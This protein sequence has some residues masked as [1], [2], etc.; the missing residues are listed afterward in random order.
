QNAPLPPLPADV[1]GP[2]NELFGIWNFEPG[3]PRTRT[4]SAGKA[5]YDPS[6]NHKRD[7]AYALMTAD[8]LANGKIEIEDAITGHPAQGHGAQQ[9]ARAV[10]ARVFADADV[11][12]AKDEAAA[13]EARKKK[14]LDLIKKWLHSY[15]TGPEAQLWK[16]PPTS[17]ELTR[18]VRRKIDE[19]LG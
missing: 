15:C 7:Y 17:D 5:T 9:G 10:T 6:F 8:L 13:Y 3:H 16:E 4:V 1:R 18:F 12:T 2:V 19:F 11:P 14:E